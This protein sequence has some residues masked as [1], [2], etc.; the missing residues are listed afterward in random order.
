MA[1]EKSTA[2]CF[3][4]IIKKDTIHI[5]NGCFQIYRAYALVY[6]AQNHKWW[7]VAQFLWVQWDSF[8]LTL[9]YEVIFYS[10]MQ[11]GN[12]SPFLSN[13][14]PW[15][16]L[17][18]PHSISLFLLDVMLLQLEGKDIITWYSC[19]TNSRESFELSLL[20]NTLVLLSCPW[21]C[22]V[23]TSWAQS[24]NGVSVM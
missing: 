18:G 13:Q 24:P 19:S 8:S 16:P 2:L 3:N 9:L 4:W 21:L 14:L 5:S 12:I 11:R 15:I 23:S 1:N 17:K 20:L 6:K 22:W 10:G 7:E